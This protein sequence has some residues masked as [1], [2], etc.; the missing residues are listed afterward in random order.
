MRVAVIGA[1]GKVGS[2]ICRAVLEHPALELVAAVDPRLAGIDLGQVLG[3]QAVGLIV[4]RDVR[5]V[6]DASAEVAIDFTQA[7]AAAVNLVRLGEAGVPAVVGTT[8]LSEEELGRIGEAYARSGVGCVVASNFSIGAILLMRAAAMVAPYFDSIEIVETH[9]EHKLDAPSGTALEIARR[10]GEA[11][12]ER[13]SDALVQGA[14]E[15]VRVDGARG[16]TVEEGVHI[17]SVRLRGAV[18]H[19]EVVFGTE[20][21]RL[22]LRHDSFDRGSFVPGVML[23]VERVHEVQGLVRGIEGFL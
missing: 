9:H 1:G 22:T 18:A 11:R 17:H 5:A 15:L 8:G 14:T 23:A 10:I 7:H 20:G 6:I 19:H 3:K 2:A 13:A 12:R 4:S 21:Q 16:A